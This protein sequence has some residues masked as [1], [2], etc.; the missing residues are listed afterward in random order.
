MLV[1]RVGHPLLKKKNLTLEELA[2]YPIIVQHSSRPQGARILRKFQQAGFEVNIVVQALDADVVKTY[3][4][5]GLGIGIIPAFSYSAREDRGLR[6][7]DVGHLFDDAVSAVLLR[8]QS[9]LQ[10]YVYAFLENLDPSLEHR[11]LEQLVLDDG[12]IA[13]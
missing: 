2:P 6:V 7:R 5:A 11:R 10:H 8:R 13:E 9:H 12:R 3:V 1:T 4:A